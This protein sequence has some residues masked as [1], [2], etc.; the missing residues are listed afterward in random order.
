MDHPSEILQQN[1]ADEPFMCAA[2]FLPHKAAVSL[3][4]SIIGNYT[5]PLHPVQFVVSETIE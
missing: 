3:Y 2:S 1:Q 5:S 4:F